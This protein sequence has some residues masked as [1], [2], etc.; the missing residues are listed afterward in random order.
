MDA[1]ETSYAASP[2]DFPFR[3]TLRLLQ[4]VSDNSDLPSAPANALE[5]CFTLTFDDEKGATHRGWEAYVRHL[6]KLY[7]GKCVAIDDVLAWNN[8]RPLKMDDQAGRPAIEA[9]VTYVPLRYQA[10]GPFWP[11]A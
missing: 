4:I 8:L 1:V 10:S 5:E 3:K 7:S 6:A 11:R 2:S 9:G